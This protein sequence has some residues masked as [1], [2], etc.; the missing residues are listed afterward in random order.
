[1][2][3]NRLHHLFEN[4][5]NTPNFFVN[6]YNVFSLILSGEQYFQYE[7]FAGT[8]PQA[9]TFSHDNHVA[10]KYQY[11]LPVS[12]HHKKY[13]QFY[14]VIKLT[15]DLKIKSNILFLEDPLPQHQHVD[16]ICK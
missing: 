7:S 8:Y 9:D 11:L 2:L 14:P 13:K 5:F 10:V 4:H 3:Y 12:Q 16:V 6:I 15:A 1:M